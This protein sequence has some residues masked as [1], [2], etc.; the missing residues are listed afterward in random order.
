[1]LPPVARDPATRGASHRAPGTR[2]GHDTP[3]T[4]NAKTDGPY[5]PFLT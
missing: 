3:E 1:M 5:S 4:A 2:N